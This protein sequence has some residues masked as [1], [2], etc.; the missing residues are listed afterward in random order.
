[1]PV[2]A[3]ASALVKRYAVEQGSE[4]L[5]SIDVLAASELSVVEVCSAVRRRERAGDI[6][7]SQADLL[8]DQVRDEFNAADGGVLVTLALTPSLLESARALLRDHP[9]R[10]GDAIQL[11][12][13]LAARDVDHRCNSV[14]C[15]D[16]RLRDAC[17]AHGFT[18]IPSII[19]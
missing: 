4:A 7:A 13:A 10:A 19:S 8:C 12:S 1:M 14:V 9:L 2:F 17:D 6:P 15:F 3:D 11:A 16:R 5:Q 18:L